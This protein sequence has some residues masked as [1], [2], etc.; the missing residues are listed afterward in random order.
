MRKCL[1]LVLFA[2]FF[3]A[4]ARSDNNTRS[5]W[6]INVSEGGL[7]P[8]PAV[9]DDQAEIAV[10]GS[11]V[12]VIWVADDPSSGGVSKSVIWYRRSRDN[13]KTWEPRVQLAVDRNLSSE[14]LASRRLA[15]DN[16][17]VVHVAWAST[18]ADDTWKGTLQYRRSPDGGTTWDAVR[19][20]YNTNAWAMWTHF[21]ITS[22]DG[23]KT[24]IGFVVSSDRAASNY[25]MLLT[26]ADGGLS[27]SSTSVFGTATSE[28]HYLLD[29]KRAGDRT[30]VMHSGVTDL[31]MGFA[32]D[33]VSVI[34]DSGSTIG[35]HTISFALSDGTHHGLIWQ[36]YEYTPKLAVAGSKAYAVFT[37]PDTSGVPRAFMRR[38]YN[39]G[40]SLDPTII[41]SGDDP[42]S[43]KVVGGEV[44][45]A[46]N[47]AYAFMVYRL[48]YTDR[49]YL[50]RY[51]EVS[52]APLAAQ[53][54]TNAAYYFRGGSNP[55]IM[56]GAGQ[57]VF[58][59]W[60]APTLTYSTDSFNTRVM[61]VLD[62]PFDAMNSANRM[63]TA[64]G[65][66]G[67][68]H[69]VVDGGFS[70]GL[71]DQDVFYGRWAPAAAPGSANKALSLSSSR[72]DLRWDLMQVPSG[73]AT[74]NFKTAMTLA[75]WVQV[76]AGGDTTGSSDVLQPI[77]MKRESVWEYSGYMLATHH[78]A[79]SRIPTA[80]IA[81]S[82]NTYWVEPPSGQSILTEGQWY[83]LAFTYDSAAAGN[84]FKLYVNGNM[85][86]Q[87]AASGQLATGD[88][89]LF[90]G[91]FGNWVIDDLSLWN[92]A[93]SQSE[94]NAIKGAPLTGSESGLALYFNFDDTT[95][96]LNNPAVSGNLL[97]Q[98]SFVASTAPPAVGPPCTFSV[99]GPV[100]NPIPAAG[101]TAT[102]TVT[103]TAGNSCTWSVTNYPTWVQQPTPP[104]GTGS[105][106]VSFTVAANSGSSSRS[107]SITVAGQT[108]T[109]AQ[110]APGITLLNA[111]TLTSLDSRP[112]GCSSFPP[113][114][115]SFAT[116]DAMVVLAITVSGQQVGDIARVDYIM[117]SGDVYA[118]PSGPWSPVDAYGASLSCYHFWD[119]AFTI[120]GTSVASMPG[121]WKAK[122]T[123]NGAPLVTL[124]F[125]VGQ[126]SAGARFVPVT[127][128][129]VVDTRNPNGSFGG[130]ILGGNTKRS[131]AVPSSSCNIPATAKA[132]SLNVTVVPSGGLGYLTLWPTGQAQPLVST[133][134]SMDGRILA[135]AAIVPAGTNGSIDV[136]AT[137]ATHVILDINGYFDS[138][139]ASALP[140]FGITPCRVADTRAMSGAF[141]PPAMGGGQERS[142]PVPSSTCGIPGSA[143]AYSLNTTVVPRQTLSYLTLFPTGQARPVVSTLNSMDG[144]VVANA[145]LLPSGSN[146]AISAYV[147][148][149]TD[150]ILDAN[151]YFAVA[152]SGTPLSFYPVT[153]CRVADTRNPTGMFGGP[154]I[155][156]GGTRSFNVTQSACGIPAT[157]KAYSLNVTVVPRGPLG[158]L[159]IWPS[160]QAQPYVSTLNSMQGAIVAN[161]AIVPAS[162][163]G[164]ISVFVSDAADVIL[165]INGYFAP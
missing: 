20:L 63:K 155:A 23:V 138:G 30:Y 77:V 61:P 36:N 158:Y 93:L 9:A 129:R 25:I 104:S 126:G 162:V 113:S 161:A 29:M 96:A 83:H 7:S 22:T 123:W 95:R 8:A 131:I 153:P 59:M 4:A 143:Q 125:T 109:I 24:S 82:V 47:D 79:P 39:Y 114:V 100:P 146:G 14:Y 84:N 87:S 43:N 34:S 97:F 127:P 133:L 1:V 88:G 72:S 74:T 151:G 92:R 40:A 70:G 41:V 49:I 48:Q 17:N 142:F 156:A 19:T 42:D 115:T 149:T 38:L 165:D 45:V 102:V 16:N 132:Y 94:I 136:Y 6:T 50:R 69:W 111:V 106:T 159:S 108:I 80:A 134:N 154:F 32:I 81:T 144:R 35:S 150:V 105:G 124:S 85:V 51:S 98:E 89:G 121:I 3:A 28:G 157:A 101:G 86:G 71:H 117:P 11:T 163:L 135:N 78:P 128:C 90:V 27:F 13:G 53:Q 65:S 5:K 54:L 99:T 152:G 120:A 33:Y 116:T 12:H 64:L 21:V 46:A 26:T 145:A 52:Q 57:S 37:G 164:M 67:V 107:G 148:D 68:V 147:T 139:N 103:V 44:S 112:T 91:Q 160:D 130:P 58:V 18:P 10:V 73:D 55:T 56:A 62:Y 15:V 118:P 60:Q 66:D 110:A 122:V 141:G 31:Y 2:L 119:T 76:N 75:A 137:D 140:F